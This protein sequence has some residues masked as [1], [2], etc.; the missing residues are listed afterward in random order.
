MP[1]R[2]EVAFRHTRNYAVCVCLRG[3]TSLN[4][5][6]TKVTASGN[7]HDYLL[8]VSPGVLVRFLLIAFGLAVV[9]YARHVFLVAF[10]AI[11]LAIL[12][13]ALA[14]LLER[15]LP[16]ATPRWCYV[17]VLS[18]LLAVAVALGYAFGS[19]AITEAHDVIE[20]IPQSIA[21]MQIALNRY[22]WGRDVTRVINH[23]VQSQQMSH[24]TTNLAGSTVQL[25]TDGIVFLVIG[26]FLG[27][28]PPLYRR[29]LLYLIPDKY[30]AQT[31][32]LLTA[33]ASRIRG[34]LLGQLIPM[35]VLGIGTFI[36]LWVLGIPLAFALGLLTSLMLF[37]PYL[38]TVLAFIPTALIAF[39]KGPASL[40]SVT[41]LYLAVHALEAYVITP[42]A[43][44]Y[45]I[46][47]PPALTLISQLFMWKVAG[48][49]GVFVATPLTAVGVVVVERVVAWR[50]GT[51]SSRVT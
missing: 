27:F 29:G 35:T 45:V 42:V 13:R 34:W 32:D 26:V 28:N 41:I 15:L 47:L 48:L 25:L 6:N 17:I 49:L 40:L 43:Q 51:S 44:R 3:R 8:C 10:A 5:S 21:N 14:R 1:A 39:T 36:G 2:Q 16:F 37:V 31:A 46:R 12:L 38:G 24:W 7:K 23:S 33:L 19:R 30:R 20:V 18:L 50:R 4:A 11:L 9:A 22:E